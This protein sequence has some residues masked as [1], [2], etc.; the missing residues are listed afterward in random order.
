MI[1]FKFNEKK[2]TQVASL[3]IEKEG[4]KIN[5]MKLI[6]LLYLVDRDALLKWERP[7]TGDAYFSM[8][9]GPVLSNVLDLINYE[10]DPD[11]NS[12]WF[13]FINKCSK[14]DVELIDNPEHDELSKAETDLIDEIYVK[15]GDL[16]QWE[17]R[18]L[19]HEILPEWENPGVTSIPIYINDILELEGKSK[20]EIEVI[21]EEVSN[22]NYVKELLSIED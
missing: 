11:D 5:H 10:E 20:E 17:I 16:N 9:N 13:K 22:I 21:E 3:F 2:A 7:L 19:S 4:N 15:F 18:D 1:R 6:K 12:Y 8:K 14:Y